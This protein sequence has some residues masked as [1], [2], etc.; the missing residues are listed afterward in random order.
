MASS[1][2][3]SPDPPSPASVGTE[4]KRLL[5][6]MGP[7][8]VRGCQCL[9]GESTSNLDSLPSKAQCSICSHPLSKHDSYG[10][11]GSRL[12]GAQ[13]TEP[14]ALPTWTAQRPRVVNEL[15]ARLDR[16][17][18][19][20]VS[21]TPASGKT[22]MMNLVANELLVRH[23]TT[24]IYILDGWEEARVESA[25]GWALYLRALVGVPGRSLR[26][27]PCYILVDDA[28]E[29][30]GDKPLW[31][32][33]FKSC[34]PGD[35]AKIVLFSRDGGPAG[36]DEHRPETY[37]QAPMTFLPHQQISLRPDGAMDPEWKPIGLLL[38]E[39]EVNDILPQL[40]P[41]VIPNGETLLTEELIH[42]L[43]LASGGHVGLLTSLV[44]VLRAM[45]KLQEPIQSRRPLNWKTACDGLFSDGP[46]FFEHIRTTIFS[47][48][49][50]KQK[51]MQNPAYA[52]V[53]KH[54]IACNRTRRLSFPSDSD[55]ERAL[56]D[57][58]RNGWLHAEHTEG[59]DT[60]YMFPTQVHRWYCQFLFEPSN[61]RKEVV[62]QSPLEMAVDAIR[63]F[64][65]DQLANPPAMPI[66]DQCQKEFYRCLFPLLIENHI[67]IAPEY[68]IPTGIRSGIDFLVP[69][70][71][72]GVDL[73]RHGDRIKQHMQ[74][75]KNKGQSLQEEPIQEY[76][77]LNFTR[78]QPRKSYPEYRGHLY[79]IIFAD[80]SRSV[81][82]VD[83]S[84]RSEV[85]TFVLAENAFFP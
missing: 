10:S 65:P 44:H 74:R 34:G 50:P 75:F 54:A 60:Y 14:Q 71:K 45:P 72:W 26:N 25:G 85:I 62:Y 48:G 64:H 6:A 73:L 83:A 19:I 82:V 20:R 59:G 1:S 21:G 38:E 46:L 61:P 36:D 18:L 47:R 81:R 35:A 70:R 13:I 15:I 49:L 43:F 57:I 11:S 9:S 76:I 53:F 69:Q 12:P 56:E 7:C 52:T 27:H 23:P 67:T 32:A 77:V 41:T 80:D 2:Q 16:Y 4:D 78:T 51:V 42:G 33:L 29:S 3:L 37:R 22:T 24:P 28:H 55:D 40:L 5:L 58:W 68:L 63:R 39:S 17:C 84:D 30:Y 8:G 66:K 31:R 79:H